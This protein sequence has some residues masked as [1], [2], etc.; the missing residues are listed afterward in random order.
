MPLHFVSF[1]GT[2]KIPPNFN[3]SKTGLKF[4]LC[5]R[6]AGKTALK[7]Q[8]FLHQAHC[9]K[10]RQGGG[11]CVCSFPRWTERKALFLLPLYIFSRWQTAPLNP[12]PTAAFHQPD[13]PSPCPPRSRTVLPLH[14]RREIINVHMS[15]EIKIVPM[16]YSVTQASTSYIKSY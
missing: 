12:F 4:C 1:T 14:P 6:K 13:C 7:E 16:S 9:I 8:Y 5:Y 11:F 3:S 10:A 15:G 2:P